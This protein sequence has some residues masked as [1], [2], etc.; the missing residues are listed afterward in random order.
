[1]CDFPHTP[2]PWDWSG[3]STEINIHTKDGKIICT[4][5]DA[6]LLEDAKNGKVAYKYSTCGPFID[7]ATYIIQAVTHYRDLVIAVENAESALKQ[8]RKHYKWD[9]ESTHSDAVN[10]AC[11]LESGLK[12]LLVDLNGGPGKPEPR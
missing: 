9:E 12:Q 11:D 5:G 2:L 6:G 8:L 3:N 10:E 7:N 1:M 4:M